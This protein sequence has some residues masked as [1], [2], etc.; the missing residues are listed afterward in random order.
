MYGKPCETPV[1]LSVKMEEL[2]RVAQK[3]RDLHLERLRRRGDRRSLPNDMHMDPVDDMKKI[4]NTW[5]QDIH[6]WMRP[7]TLAAYEEL[8]HNRRYEDAHQLGEE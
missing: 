6:S 1:P 4:Y 5:R 7:S 8:E 2:L 3:Q